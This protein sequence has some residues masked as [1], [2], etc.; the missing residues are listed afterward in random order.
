[1][2]DKEILVKE[3]QHIV[4]QKLK[5]NLHCVLELSELIEIFD[6]NVPK[7]ILRDYYYKKYEKASEETDRLE[8]EYQC[9]LIKSS[10]L[11]NKLEELG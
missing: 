4:D 2:T 3:V 5:H 1:M 10:Q 7:E 8:Q 9:Q 6:I 11:L